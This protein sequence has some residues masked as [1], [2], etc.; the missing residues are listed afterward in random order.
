[1]KWKSV[2]VLLGLIILILVQPTEAKGPFTQVIISGPQLDQPITVTNPLALWFLSFGTFEDF[3]QAGTFQA[4]AD[5]S[6]IGYD[7]ERQWKDVAGRNF[8][9]DTVSYH[10]NVNPLARGYIHMSVVGYGT[11]N[12]NNKWFH[13]T[14][15]G[16]IALRA[17]VLGEQAIDALI[18]PD[19]VSG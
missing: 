1:M 7:L 14:A 13:V 6:E 15:I 12:T 19:G 4:P 3:R 5:A 2:L 17:V 16:E 10:P 11:T 9:F 18:S 8:T